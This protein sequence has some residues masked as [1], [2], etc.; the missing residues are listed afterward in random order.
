MEAE[1]LI[2]VPPFA[3]R[4]SELQGWTEENNVSWL[5]VSMVKFKTGRELSTKVTREPGSPGCLASVAGLPHWGSDELDF[6]YPE[7]RP[8]G[9]LAQQGPS[10][11]AVGQAGMSQVRGGACAFGPRRRG[12]SGLAPGE[13]G[14]WQ[15]QAGDGPEQAETAKGSLSNDSPE[16]V[17]T[18]D[19]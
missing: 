15:D 16:A 1:Q 10:W 5:A 4:W 11:E 17:E 6:V 19:G 8:P 12:A 18:T 9:V 2:Y 3:Q 7:N 13:S 14:R